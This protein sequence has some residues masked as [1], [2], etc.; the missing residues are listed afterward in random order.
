[1]LVLQAWH[2]IRLCMCV[3]HVRQSYLLPMFA[4]SILPSWLGCHCNEDAD[5]MAWYKKAANQG[6]SEAQYCI[7]LA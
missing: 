7:G 4:G 2:D 6:H 1:M 3:K 5:A